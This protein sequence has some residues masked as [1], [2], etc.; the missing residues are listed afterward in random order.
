LI[1]TE[2]GILLENIVFDPVMISVALKLAIILSLSLKAN[3]HPSVD[4]PV[5]VVC[6]L[7]LVSKMM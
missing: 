6:P 7:L 1:W 3:A 5:Y 4:L 2:I